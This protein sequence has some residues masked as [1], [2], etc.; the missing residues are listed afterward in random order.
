M[1]T[2]AAT[3]SRL[4]SSA[5]LAS[6]AALMTRLTASDAQPFL[7]PPHI[8]L[9]DAEL[10]RMQFEPIRLIVE[11]P[12]R[13]GKS[14]LVSHALPVWFLERFPHKHVI[15]GA[16]ESR[17]AGSWGR[18]VRDTITEHP[19]TLRVRVRRDVASTSEWI[20]TK[21]GGMITAGVGGPITGRGGDLMIIDDPVKNMTDARSRQ[22]QETNAD[23]YRSV[24]R[25][26][27][28]PGASIVIIQTRWHED[29]LS[30]LV[31]TGR[32]SS[33]GMAA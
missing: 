32:V 5:H 3:R 18:K 19:D 33:F 30:G 4:R 12:P 6:P 20:T 8:D 10:A 28:A 11:M 31:Q 27:L 29:D 25:T 14:N 21:G 23:W 1:S 17:F 15:L 16:Y 9:I 26:R 24:I 22:K 7:W 2:L 13:H